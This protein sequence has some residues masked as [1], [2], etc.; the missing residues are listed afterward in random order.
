MD[1]THRELGH[2]FGATDKAPMLRPIRH[3]AHLLAS[4]QQEGV[5]LQDNMVSES[6]RLA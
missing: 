4:R 2:V 5:P 6:P 3:S 1:I